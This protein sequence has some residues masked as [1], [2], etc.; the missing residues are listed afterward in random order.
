[1]EDKF[2]KLDLYQG[3]LAGGVHNGR[4]FE[5]WKTRLKTAKRKRSEDEQHVLL[6]V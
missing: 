6:S 5:R 3:G 1:M 2:Q 4:Q